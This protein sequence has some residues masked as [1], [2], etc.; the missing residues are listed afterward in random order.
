[1]KRER[2]RERDREVL[3]PGF[4]LDDI[5]SATASN[6]GTL[7]YIYTIFNYLRKYF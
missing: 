5:H 2:D 4:E 7:H 6:V 3:K 1:M